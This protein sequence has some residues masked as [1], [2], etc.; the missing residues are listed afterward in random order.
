MHVQELIA[1]TA[2]TAD[3]TTWVE[4]NACAPNDAASNIDEK[5]AAPTANSIRVT[6]NCIG[7]RVSIKL[8]SQSTRRKHV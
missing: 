4:P 7:K 1:A 8:T 2:E 3:K 5:S 6:A